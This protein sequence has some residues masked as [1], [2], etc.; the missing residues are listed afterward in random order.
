MAPKIGILAYGSL[1]DSPGFEIEEATTETVKGLETPFK[2]E[3]ARTSRGRK[4]APTLVPY[5]AGAH[6]E[7]RIF[8]VDLPEAEAANRL[9]RREIN[10]VGSGKVY[11]RPKEEDPDKVFV[12]SWKQ[13]AGVD[14]V[15]Y[16]RI[17]ANIKNLSPAELPSLAVKSAKLLGDGRDGISYLINAKRNG[18]RTVLSDD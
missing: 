8:V 2:V 17:G 18:I 6:V 13:L 15:L 1:I 10:E 11:V 9:Y 12:E 5:D 14:L 7:A 3:Y 4:G 16:T